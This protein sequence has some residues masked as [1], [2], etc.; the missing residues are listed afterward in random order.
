M[1][2]RMA[3]TYSDEQIAATLNRMGLRTGVGN[4]WNEQ[5]VYA[6]RR[7]QNLTG[8]RSRAGDTLTLRGRRPKDSA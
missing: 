5:R 7:S 6:L 2:R 3:P 4:T 8:P 1:V